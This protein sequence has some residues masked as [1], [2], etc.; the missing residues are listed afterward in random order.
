MLMSE[1]LIKWE[2][3]SDNLDS[4]F[5]FLL[6]VNYLLYDWTEDIG[7]DWL[8]KNFF[9]AV[10]LIDVIDLLVIHRSN[11]INFGVKVLI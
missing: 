11:C 4:I 5:I 10:L 1:T 8:G 7:S 9:Y 6:L 2:M 3:S